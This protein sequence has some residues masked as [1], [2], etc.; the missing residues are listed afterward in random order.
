MIQKAQDLFYQ[1]EKDQI[2]AQITAGKHRRKYERTAQF[3]HPWKTARFKLV[4]KYK[5]GNQ[6]PYYSLD[7]VVREDE[8]YR[9]DEWEGLQSLFRLLQKDWIH[10][11]GYTIWMHWNKIPDKKTNW[12][13][14]MPIDR[15]F[16][17]YRHQE[18]IRFRETKQG[19]LV[20]KMEPFRD[21][22][23]EMYYNK[24]KKYGSNT[25]YPGSRSKA[26]KTAGQ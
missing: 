14:I 15:L 23:R 22:M 17:G 10:V 5:D 19:H 26:P 13:Y 7:H 8:T 2:S 25:S 16:K 6:V 21:Q 18:N 11:E 24:V 4:V 3:N 12:G 1:V 20:V 9:K